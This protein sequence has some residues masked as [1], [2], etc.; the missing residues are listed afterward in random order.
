MASRLAHIGQM[1]TGFAGPVAF[2][3]GAILSALWFPPN[4]RAT[5]TAIGTIS[6]FAGAALCFIIGTCSRKGDF[7]LQSTEYKYFQIRQM[8]NGR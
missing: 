2:T 4:Q 5:A 1:F 3:G 8:S 6:G 7:V